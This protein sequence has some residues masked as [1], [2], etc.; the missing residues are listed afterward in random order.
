MNISVAQS[1]Q[2]NKILIYY[3]KLVNSFSLMKS[4]LIQGNMQDKNL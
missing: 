2:E 1:I 3:K 4:S